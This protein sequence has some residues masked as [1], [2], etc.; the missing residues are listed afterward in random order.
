MVN[1]WK[2]WKQNWTILLMLAF[3]RTRDGD[4][5]V[6]ELSSTSGKGLK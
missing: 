1:D 3:N 4:E 2:K 5:V 6:K